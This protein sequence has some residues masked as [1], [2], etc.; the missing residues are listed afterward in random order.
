MTGMPERLS[1]CHNLIE[2]R[3][4]VDVQTKKVWRDFMRV[5]S[6]DAAVMYARACRAW[7]GPRAPRIVRSKIEELRRAGDQDGVRA[8]SQVADQLLQLPSRS[9]RRAKPSSSIAPKTPMRGHHE[10]A[11]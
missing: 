9:T 3:E 8:W 2:S 10:E 1:I 5:T 4:G 6:E 7:Y 11:P